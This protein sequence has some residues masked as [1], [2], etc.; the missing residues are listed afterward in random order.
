MIPVLNRKIVE[1]CFADIAFV[2]GR[3]SVAQA[4]VSADADVGGAAVRVGERRVVGELS[5][6]CRELAS[7]LVRSELIAPHAST[8]SISFTTRGEIVAVALITRLRPG[9]LIDI[10]FHARIVA[11]TPQRE[12]G[13]LRYDILHVA[14]VNSHF[15]ADILVEADNV[16]PEVVQGAVWR[17]SAIPA[18]LEDC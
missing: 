3:R 18:N 5:G 7:A 4:S 15:I 10:C 14:C 2:I 16:L 12:W 9:A 8:N 17:I 1:D 6:E 11:A 13:I